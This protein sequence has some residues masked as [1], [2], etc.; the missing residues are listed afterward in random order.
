MNRIE[1][2]ERQILRAA[3]PSMYTFVEQGIEH[4]LTLMF[5]EESKNIERVR[6]TVASLNPENYP[7]LAKTLILNAANSMRYTL[8]EESI[9]RLSHTLQE[10]VARDL[11]IIPSIS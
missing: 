3:F 10:N 2:I 8:D 5:N 6:S 4:G 7:A 9:E 11:N 1:H